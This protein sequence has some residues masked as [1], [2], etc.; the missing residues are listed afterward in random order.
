[1]AMGEVKSWGSRITSIVEFLS[2]LSSASKESS[3]VILYDSGSK[4]KERI[5]GV[6]PYTR[7][8]RLQ[9]GITVIGFS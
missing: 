8:E 5:R 3:R 4:K 6:R 7:R 9:W 2:W 1:M